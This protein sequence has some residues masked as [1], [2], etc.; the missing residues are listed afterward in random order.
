MGWG[1]SWNEEFTEQR[2]LVSLVKRFNALRKKHPSFLLEGRMVKPPFKYASRQTKLCVRAKTHGYS[3]EV[4]EVFISFWE[5]AE[6]KRIGFATN[7][8]REPSDFRITRDDG[9]PETRRLAPLETI[10]LQADDKNRY[11]C[12]NVKSK[13]CVLEQEREKP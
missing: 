5:N 1:R 2:E 13:V 12:L 7:W 8:R 9:H 6:G 10:E 11:G 4:P 3:P